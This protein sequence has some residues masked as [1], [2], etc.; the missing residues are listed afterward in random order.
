MKFKTGDKV[1][2][3]ELTGIDFRNTNLKEGMTGKVTKGGND[4]VQVKFDES[5]EHD[6]HNW[7]EDTESYDMFV[8]Q[9]ELLKEDCIVIYRKDKDVIALD[10]S[11]GKKAVAKCSSKDSFDF[12]TGAKLAFERLYKDKQETYNG[13]ICVTSIDVIG[14]Q[15][16]NL[17]VGKIYEIKDGKFINDIGCVFPLTTSLSSVEEL[18]EYLRADDNNNRNNVMYHYSVSHVHF[19]EVVD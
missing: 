4:V 17:T 8:Y 6:Y 3:I 19:V 7:H 13:K 14:N 10:K 11:T 12:K 9:L 2:V 5:F 15:N 18:V 1:K 16:A